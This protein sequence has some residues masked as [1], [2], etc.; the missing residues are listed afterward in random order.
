L[1]ALAAAAETVVWLWLEL[2]RHGAVDRALRQGTAGLLLRSGGLLTGPLALVLR[3]L[4][5]WFS[6]ALIL[7]DIAFLAGEV[8][9]RFGWVEAGHAS[10]RDP[11]AVFASTTQD[12]H[13]GPNTDQG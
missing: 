9:H 1:G 12:G 10:A 4:A 6:P 13:S 2:K 7:A 11:E 8:A 3:A 5:F